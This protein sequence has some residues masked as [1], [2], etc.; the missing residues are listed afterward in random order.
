MNS[1]CY[2]EVLKMEHAMTWLA[3]LKV[4]RPPCAMAFLVAKGAKAQQIRGW[5]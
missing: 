2:S 3:C 1:Q 4:V 5:R